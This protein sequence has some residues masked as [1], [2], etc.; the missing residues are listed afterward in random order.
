[1]MKRFIPVIFSLVCGFLL[2]G[3]GSSET[4]DLSFFLSKE[5]KMTDALING[6]SQDIDLNAFRLILNKDFTFSRVNLN[7]EED[8]GS[9][10]LANGNNQVELEST[11]L[12]FEEYLIVELQFR[13]LE[14][15]VIQ[16]SDK[17]GETEFRYILEPVRP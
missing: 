5:W 15:Q 11:S 14:L 17:V 9:W 4:P 13:L 1:M 12:G 16:G 3:C 2:S 7:G 10:A 6:E 8:E